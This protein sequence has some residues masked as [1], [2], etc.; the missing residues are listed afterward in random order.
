[1]TIF[2]IISHNVFS[3]PLLNSV[4]LMRIATI[5]SLCYKNL[6]FTPKVETFNTNLYLD[7]LYWN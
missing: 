7:G 1:M 4:T 5:L 2:D 6:R 3:K